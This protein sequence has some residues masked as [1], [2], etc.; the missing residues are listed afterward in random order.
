[1]KKTSIQALNGSK[2]YKI[3][4]QDL[5]IFRKEVSPI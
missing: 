2:F 3:T 5:T 1:M 4:A